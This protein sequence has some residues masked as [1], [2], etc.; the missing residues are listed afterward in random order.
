M[1]GTI[2]PGKQRKAQYE[3][4]LRMQGKNMAA[5]L[6]KE[7]RTKHGVRS[8]AVRVGDTVKV[9]RGDYLGKSGN[10]NQVDRKR[11][12]VYIQGVMRKKTDGKEAFLGFRPSNVMIIGIDMK[13]KKRIKKKTTST[14]TLASGKK[15]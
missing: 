14:K 10:V 7:L 8:L 4:D 11:N 6:S 3:A 1:N 13:D 5:P 15:E 9:L 12:K 2:N